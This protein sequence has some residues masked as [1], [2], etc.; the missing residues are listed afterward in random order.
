LIRLVLLKLFSLDPKQGKI[1]FQGKY[2]SLLRHDHWEFVERNH[3]D[4][5]VMMVPVTE[6]GKVVLL[7]QY[8]TPMGKRIIEWPAGLVS[9]LAE[10][11]GEAW[12]DAARRELLEETGYQAEELRLL[13]RG[14]PSPGM[15]NELVA[16]Y[17]AKGLKKVGPG[18]GDPTEDIVVHEVP[19]QEVESWLKKQ[20]GHGHTVDPKVYAGLYFII[21]R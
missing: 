4:G 2:L 20:E 5:A 9:D 13:T 17:L 3:C 11:R 16:I 21:P 19:L 7:E 18:G 12:E 6:E 15:S 10:H 8:R 1:L 14:P